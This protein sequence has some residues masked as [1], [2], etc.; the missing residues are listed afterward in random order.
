[1]FNL[2]GFLTKNGYPVDESEVK[3]LMRRLNGEVGVNDKRFVDD[4]K[5]IHF[6]KPVMEDKRSDSDW[7]LEN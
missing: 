4:A 5:F 7:E 1:M 3:F 2:S 6:L